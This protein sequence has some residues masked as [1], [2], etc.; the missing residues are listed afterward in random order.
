MG[1]IANIGYTDYYGVVHRVDIDMDGYSG[2]NLDLKGTT[3]P[4]DVRYESLAPK[5]LFGNQ[6][7]KSNVT[8]E[9]YIDDPSAKTLVDNI[10]AST[11]GNYQLKYYKN[12]SL[13]R[14]VDLLPDQGDY[15]EE[16]TGRIVR[17]SGKDFSIL[18]GDVYPLT[19]GR[20]PIIEVIADVLP[21]GLPITTLT[22]W[23]NTSQTN[24][25]RDFLG[26]IYIERRALRNYASRE[27][28]N[29]SAL[30]QLEVLS[31]LARN[32]KLFIKQSGGRW[33]IEQLSAYKTPSSVLTTL[34]DTNGAFVSASNTNRT[35][36]GL[37]IRDVSTNTQL[38]GLK[39][40][41]YTFNHRTDE[42]GIVLPNEIVFVRNN[43]AS[44]SFSQTILS[45]GSQRLDFG[46]FVEVRKPDI[47]RAQVGVQIRLQNSGLYWNQQR[48]IWDAS[49]STALF[50]I[51]SLNK[52][53]PGDDDLT[54]FTYT[55]TV[56]VTTNLIPLSVGEDTLI[57]TLVPH[58]QSGCITTFR[59][60][61][62]SIIRSD[63][64][65]AAKSIQYQL[66]QTANWSV[67][68]DDGIVLYG[69]GPSPGV[70]SALSTSGV[71]TSTTDGGW[72][73][74]GTVTDWSFQELLTREVMEFQQSTVRWLQANI[75]GD[76]D[77]SK[78]VIYDSTAFFVIGGEYDVYNG[79][80]RSCQLIAI[81]YA[82]A[83]ANLTVGLIAG[84]QSIGQGLYGALTVNAQRTLEAGG[85]ISY[86]LAVAL[87][88]GDVS[89]IVLRTELDNPT[90]FRAGDVLK[91]VH[92]V[93]LDFDDFIV[94]TDQVSG[95]N[96]VN[97]NTLTIDS[98]YPAGSY[99]F[100]SAESI[101][102]GIIIARNS[103]LR[104]ARGQAHGELTANVNGLVS[105]ITANLW[106]RIRK[107]EDFVI[108]DNL[109]G[110]EYYITAAE[111]VDAGLQTFDIEPTI[112]NAVTGSYINQD[113]SQKQ[114]YTYNDPGTIQL[115][116]ERLRTKN[117]IAVLSTELPLGPGL[118]SLPITDAI[119]IDLL[120]NQ[121]ITVQNRAGDSQDFTVDGDQSITGASTTITVNSVTNLVYFDAGDSVF[122]AGGLASARITINS[123]EIDLRVSFNNVINSINI[124]T[125]GIRIQGS[126]ITIDGNVNFSNGYDPSDGRTVIR[127][128]TAPTVR[129][130]GDPLVT[131]D[132]WIETDAGDRIRVWNGSGWQATETNINGGRITTGTI[133]ADLVTVSSNGG[134]VT[135]SNLGIR[136]N[137]SGGNQDVLIDEDGITLQFGSASAGGSVVDGKTIDW[138]QGSTV[139]ANISSTTQGN[140]AGFYLDIYSRGW[141][142]LYPSFD[143]SLSGSGA[144]RINM[145][146]LG[147]PS[148]VFV[149][150]TH[151]GD[152]GTVQGFMR[153]D[154]TGNATSTT[155]GALRVPNGGISVGGA[156]W[157]GSSI[158]ANSL[159]VGTQTNKATISYTTN[160]AR[161]LTIPNVGGNRTFAFIDQAQT[162]SAQQSFPHLGIRLENSTSAGHYAT[163]Q[164]GTAA[165]RTYTFSGNTGTVWT[166]GNLAIA[167]ISIPAPFTASDW[168]TFTFGGRQFAV[169]AME[170]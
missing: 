130:S 11:E 54:E 166:T 117:A 147:S 128:D 141:I 33:Y 161:T 156:S 169:E 44:R 167:A 42:Q 164:F 19:D 35:Q 66:T 122:E 60:T 72:Y 163:F 45:D 92:P 96:V 41:S 99:A 89:Q 154:P 39:R 26:Q 118:T 111:S 73:R 57:V 12:G 162:F 135:I 100:L 140:L 13:D 18:S 53:D 62:F 104:Y 50:D 75:L 133:D 79:E 116:V 149:E 14:I 34:Y 40:V 84:A 36:S 3:K 47:E 159:I 124:S 152:S 158:T 121:V 103:I 113:G 22:S 64:S 20:V 30:L 125:E 71:A 165:N 76:L 145:S 31:L 142:N 95:N 155:T 37:T 6:V 91:V 51:G 17:L 25:A 153:I 70:A 24:T 32:F 150:T 146:T 107:G 65:I 78:V 55:S 27:D 88:V 69:D 90:L 109:S 46:A 112:V 74:R 1:V 67:N 21:Y 83:T 98:F 85:A 127:S 63:G 5:L 123:D 68:Y 87:P 81:S 58:Q 102:A 43:T 137:P 143:P 48:S 105:S 10:A 138:K 106:A 52:V 110:Q 8:I 134:D 132:E 144:P 129:P 59:D 170:L 136:V 80:W 120:D 28:E 168:V 108:Q 77:A 119:T 126:R 157:F 115:G 151:V 4:I 93:T 9:F 160:T 82:D 56:S 61:Q 86:R 94:T 49:P 148:T 2:S 29:D 131:G 7:I 38:P 23:V 16:S 97:V 101:N 114:S 139:T 15:T